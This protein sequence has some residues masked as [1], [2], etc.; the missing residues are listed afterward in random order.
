MLDEIRGALARIDPGLSQYDWFR[1]A[2]ALYN[3]LGDEGFSLFDRWSSGSAKYPGPGKCWQQWVYS[4]RYGEVDPSGDAQPITIGTVFWLAKQHDL[5]Q[6][7]LAP[8]PQLSG[9]CEHCG[10]AGL[11]E[12]HHW[13]PAAVFVD[14]DAWPTGN[15][16]RKCHALWHDKMAQ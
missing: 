14:F 11:I 16:C 4:R 1:V 9:T 6:T 3:A 12:R 2:A 7:K 5:P 15:L 10:T 8:P 13:A